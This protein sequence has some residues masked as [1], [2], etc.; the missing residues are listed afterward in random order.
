MKLQ[1]KHTNQTVRICLGLLAI[2]LLL[3]FS[4]CATQTSNLGKIAP[5]NEVIPL[6]AD[7]GT[8]ERVWQTKDVEVFYRTVKTVAHLPLKV[9]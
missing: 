5:P 6:V 8:K 2:V 3:V 7:D 1:V 4:A 9:R